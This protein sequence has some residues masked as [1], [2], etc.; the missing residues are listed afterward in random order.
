MHKLPLSREE[1]HLKAREFAK[2]FYY[3]SHFLNP[4]FFQG[5]KTVI[6]E[7]LEDLNFRLPDSIIIPIGNGSLILGVI[8]GIYDLIRSKL[9]K[10]FPKIIGVQSENCAPIYEAY[11][12]KSFDIPKIEKRETLAEGIAI[13]NPIR[14]KEIL[15][16][17]YETKG[18]VLTVTEEEILNAQ[19]EL[20][21]RGIFVE[22]TSAVQFAGF[23]KYIRNLNKKELIVV[24]LTGSGLKS[25]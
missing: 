21:K 19:E 25:L 11:K 10:A 1:V 7:I 14:G 5:T 2:N 15:K 17:I 6:Y 16:S 13:S 4:Y 8:T 12:I 18:E 22:P 3:V 23:K 20:G 9:I 24:I